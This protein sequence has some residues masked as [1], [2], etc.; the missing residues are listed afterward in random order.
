[1]SYRLH[2]E[3]PARIRTWNLLN[4]EVTVTYATEQKD[5]GEQTEPGAE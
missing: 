4:E 3:E 5:R 1:L 2:S